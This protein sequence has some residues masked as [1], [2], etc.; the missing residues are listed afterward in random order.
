MDCLLGVEEIGGAAPFLF[1]LIH[2]SVYFCY[3]NVTNYRKAPSFLLLRR[4]RIVSFLFVFSTAPS[5]P[6]WRGWPWRR[7]GGKVLLPSVL[8]LHP[9]PTGT[10]GIGSFPKLAIAQSNKSELTPVI[11]SDSTPSST[12]LRRVAGSLTL[13]PSAH[14]PRPELW[15]LEKLIISTVPPEFPDSHLI[16]VIQQTVTVCGPI[17]HFAIGAR[18]EGYEHI[19][20]FRR[21]VPVMRRPNTVL[22]DSFLIDIQNSIQRIYLSFEEPRC[23]K[24]KAEGHVARMCN[25]SPPGTVPLASTFLQI[26]D[27][28]SH[29]PSSNKPAPISGEDTH[30][31]ESPETLSSHRYTQGPGQTEKETTELPTKDQERK[32][33]SKIPEDTPEAARP[34]LTQSESPSFTENNEESLA[35]ISELPD[36]QLVEIPCPTSISQNTSPLTSTF[37]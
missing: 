23:Y 32:E 4:G 3:L 9:P 31:K 6:C 30:G 19:L 2:F 24:C 22:P 11:F 8:H 7:V 35:A 25:S 13:T 16:D 27:S 36:T 34:I 28:I 10:A 14:R 5:S 33:L 20:S 26:P 18:K 37:M 21:A 17:K 15:R 29:H 12:I 1:S